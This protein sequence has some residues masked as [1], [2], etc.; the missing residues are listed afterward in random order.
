M[1]VD[2]SGGFHLTTIVDDEKPRYAILSHTWGP[3]GSE[4]T[5]KD[6]QKGEGKSKDGYYKLRFCAMQ[7]QRD[8]IDHF[9]IDTCCIDKKNSVELGEAITSMFRW[10]SEATRCY[11]L[12]SDCSRRD[13][14][15][16]NAIT[17]QRQFRHSRWFTRGWTLQELLAPRILDFFSL[18]GG[19]LGDK[20]SLRGEIERIT[21][22]PET[23]ITGKPLST[24]D[25]NCR[26]Q[27]ASNRSTKREE[28]EAYCLA[29]L[30]GVSVRPNYGERRES[31][32]RHLKLEIE[33]KFKNELYK[34]VMPIYN[35]EK[36]FES[37]EN[38]RNRLYTSL[39][40]DIVDARRFAIKQACRGT[41]E[42]LV[43]HQSIS[44]W[45]TDSQFDQHRGLLWIRGKPGA[46]K[47][48]LLNFLYE[49]MQQ[50]KTENDVI[51]SF[52]FN[53][54]GELQERSTTGMWLGLV[55]QLLKGVPA[56]KMVL[57]T[58][59]L[60]LN[61]GEPKWTENMLVGI[62][63]VAI[64]ML[65]PRC[66]K[67]FVD[68][69]DECDED[70]IR[71]MVD[72]FQDIGEEAV[73]NGYKFLVCFSS[74]PYPTINAP[75]G[76]TMSLERET[77]HAKDIE[78]YV[79]KRLN[80]GKS[81]LAEGVKI[82]LL[83]KA[84]GVFLW[85]VVVVVILNKVFQKGLIHAV[86]RK[87]EELH[88]ELSSLF[89]DILTR[90]CADMD[91]TLLCFQ[92]V[93]FA[94]QP[95][96]I[97]EFYLAM[98]SGS[99]PKSTFLY[100]WINSDVTDETMQRFVTNSSKGL[101]EVVSTKNPNNEHE[102][103]VQFIHESVREY[104]LDYHGLP[105]LW[106]H[107]ALGMGRISQGRL[108]E[109]CRAYMQAIADKVIPAYCS[110][111]PEH[112]LYTAFPFLKCAS[113]HLAAFAKSDIISSQQSQFLGI[114]IDEW[115]KVLKAITS[116]EPF[117]NQQSSR[118]RTTA[119]ILFALIDTGCDGAV[120]LTLER[121]DVLNIVSSRGRTVL[122]HAA[123]C[124]LDWGVQLLLAR[125]ADAGRPDADGMRPLH[126]AVH[127]GSALC[128]QHL[129]VASTDVDVQDTSGRRPLHIAAVA[130]SEPCLELLLAAGASVE[131][132]IPEDSMTALHLAA[133]DNSVDVLAALLDR[134]AYI[135]AKS[136][137]RYTALHW[138]ARYRRLETLRV[139]LDRGADLEAE[140]SF[141]NT[142]FLLAIDLNSE[143][144]WNGISLSPCAT[145]LLNRGADSTRV[146][147]KG[148]GLTNVPAAL[149][150]AVDSLVEERRKTNQSATGRLWWHLRVIPYY[151]RSLHL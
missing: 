49:H 7:A 139:L 2:G 83:R 100:D 108:E 43:R 105:Q 18:D 118:R 28:D 137:N 133:R 128:V 148:H 6:I 75:Y 37:I 111:Q 143:V 56:L 149:R 69:L 124:G 125:N 67:C 113:A 72:L 92:W 76:L 132:P 145:L 144:G 140:D 104:L 101:A 129:L 131:A 46:G 22:I 65:G 95:L 58:V 63:K 47:S 112:S 54:R 134:G 42:W 89:R 88:P 38:R 91:E 1:K 123:S 151:A 73:E 62:F 3:D 51:I 40:R 142:P 9:W 102:K 117:L 97:Q 13:G 110:S 103:R 57:D 25:I 136:Y 86:Q 114:G 5:F 32:M 107:L 87:L 122:H 96:K 74:R 138:A 80:I 16:G 44:D 127:S 66:L 21:G 11:A 93:L 77:E 34:A 147:K 68:A 94:R 30:F 60:P 109:C 48:T 33:S 24:F 79:A 17:F 126:H 64:R 98:I 10:Y 81:A 59:V 61:T 106:P 119:E 146:N 35:D 116:L 52:F 115:V 84:N 82:E 19:H 50:Q 71:D 55:A 150:H 15:P 39:C 45:L 36:S 23:A 53:A 90:D 8:G 41:C 135:E 78:R 31:A 29:G 12:L 130:N 85:V 4:V 26:L 70:S 120:R 20:N 141:G 27:W 121:G 14:S 99:D